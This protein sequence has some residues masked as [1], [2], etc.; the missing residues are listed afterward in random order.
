MISVVIIGCGR[1]AQNHIGALKRIKNAAIVGVCDKDEAKA[2][3]TAES[4]GCEAFTDGEAML[5]KLHPQAAVICVPTFVHE[6]AVKLCA[7]HR[8]AVLCEKPLER[9]TGACR[10]LLDAVEEADIIFMTAQVVRHWPGFVEIKEMMDKGELGTVYSMRFR[11]VT[12]RD[13]AVAKWLN[14]PKLGGGAIHDM[15]VH[16]VDFLRYVAGPFESGYASGVKDEFGCYNDV[17][18]SIVCKNGIHASAEASFAMQTGYPFSFSVCVNAS[19]ATLEYAYHAGIRIAD[20]DESESVMRI[21]RKGKGMEVVKIEEEDAFYRQMC[22]FLSCVE[23]GEKPTL[24]TPAESYEV[25]KMVDAL[26]ESVRTH[27]A[28]TLDDYV[29]FDFKK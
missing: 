26:H 19:E 28:I 8:V 16:D 24:I 2:Q 27:Q 6:E 18:A 21:W 5:V 25:I 20:T 10:R 7:K 1:I 13:D 23:K 14:M 22:Y 3:K 11:R 15:L 29:P 12:S 9:T 17:M 4:L